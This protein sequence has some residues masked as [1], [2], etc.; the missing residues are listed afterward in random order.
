MPVV[1]TF[2][3][4][5]SP[6]GN[7]VYVTYAFTDQV[8]VDHHVNRLVPASTDHPQALI[9]LTPVVD[10]RMIEEE[11]EA[12]AGRVLDGENPEQI[13]NNPVHTTTKRLAK[14]LL[15]WMMRERDPYIV[16]LLEPLIVYIRA[17]FNAAQIANLLD[18]TTDQVT[19]LNTRINRILD[20]KD[21]FIAFRND[22]E[23]FGAA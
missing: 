2:V 7:R 5:L 1:T 16:I 15:F 23:D 12:A 9:D 17:N 3:K 4:S 21:D 20:N 22:A 11:V 14:R 6:S 13:V 10:A 18:L 19:R 8:G